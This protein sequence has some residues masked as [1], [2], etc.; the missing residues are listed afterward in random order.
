M[1]AVDAASGGSIE[2]AAN[3]LA[4]ALEV[5]EDGAW[6]LPASRSFAKAKLVTK[7]ETLE[8][9]GSA[10]SPTLARTRA[11]MECVERFAQFANAAPVTTISAT[12]ESVEPE[13]VSPWLCGLYSRAQY[14][15]WEFPCEPYSP[16]DVI[17]WVQ[18][19]DLV[20][21][22]TRLL[23]VEFIYPR[24]PLRRKPLVVETSNGTAA[25]VDETAASLGAIC[26]VIERDSLMLFWYRQPRTAAIAIADVPDRHLREELNAIVDMGFV[27]LLCDLAYDLGIPCF[28]VWALQQNTVAYGA[29][30]AIDPIESLEHAVREL[31]TSLR[32]VCREGPASTALFPL[33]NV[34]SPEH[35]RGLYHRGPLHDVLRQLLGR[36]VR[37]ERRD[38]MKWEREQ[39]SLPRLVETL[40][41]RGYIPY[42]YDLTPALPAV[43]GI[44]VVRVIVPGLVPL[45]FGHDRTR[46]GCK[47]LSGKE[48]PGRFSTTLPHFMS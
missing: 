40:A 32:F 48:G 43:T 9:F 26:E 45:H 36:I 21:A 24:A 15:T 4:V 3:D 41:R 33:N 37:P 8:G 39:P 28:L 16:R 35:H 17:E 46:F 34:R 7:S 42:S 5:E 20:R 31:G 6:P 1:H 11:V 38:H 13:A 30:C 2:A 47:R 12:G 44:R 29:G 25:H 19:R 27:V 23:P 18:V 10:A 22:G 14:A